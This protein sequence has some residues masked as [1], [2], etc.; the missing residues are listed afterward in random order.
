MNKACPDHKFAIVGYSQG[1]MVMHLEFDNSTSKI[2]NS[3]LKQVVGGAMFGTFYTSCDLKFHVH[4][5][6]Q[7][8]IQPRLLTIR[9]EQS[10][11]RL[12]YRRRHCS[13]SQMI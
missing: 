1:A 10:H 12:A 5:T 6:K 11:C 9:V 13:N 3:A 8:V 4:L 2:S 7:Q